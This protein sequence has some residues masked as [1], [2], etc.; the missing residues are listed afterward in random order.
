MTERVPTYNDIREL[1]EKVNAMQETLVEHRVRL[2]NGTKVFGG[3]GTRIAGL[4][5]VTRP[6]PVSVSKV[7][8]ITFTIVMAGAVALWGL[9]N[10]LRD[11]PTMDQIEHVVEQHDATGHQSIREDVRDI[12]AAQEIQQGLIEGATGKLDTLL[13]RTPESATTH[14]RR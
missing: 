2:E 8:G 12:K 14:H 7:A 1:Q 13:E 4:E 6:K 3:Y 10:L 5:E 9:A 11:R